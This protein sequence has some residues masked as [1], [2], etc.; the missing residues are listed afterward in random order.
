MLPM[1][2]EYDDNIISIT[3]NVNPFEDG[4]KK[5]QSRPLDCIKIKANFKNAH[6]IQFCTRQYPNIFE[7]RE[8]G[9]KTQKWEKIRPFYMEDLINPQWK[10]VGL[11]KKDENSI[12]MYDD[13]SGVSIPK[14]DRAV[15]CTFV[16]VEG[17]IT[18]L[19]QWSKEFIFED[20]I[21]NYSVNVE[22]WENKELPL[23]A[24]KILAQE[25]KIPTELCSK[26]LI[27]KSKQTS[28]E[29]IKE[30]SRGF[31]IN[32][33]SNWYTVLK[34]PEFFKKSIELKEKEEPNIKGIFDKL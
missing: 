22:K 18:H 20:G 21:A 15:F 14:A 33:P 9:G 30:E 7:Y 6:F 11:H 17:K 24:V 1:K 34:Y 2:N 26:E 5:F 28:E 10:E 4:V 16:A 32:P 3:L 12:S 13:P 23:W 29:I 31:F 25:S 19:V 27:E 8:T